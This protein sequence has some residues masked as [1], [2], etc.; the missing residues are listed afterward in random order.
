MQ[1]PKAPRFCCCTLGRGLFMRRKWYL[2]GL[3]AFL[4]SGVSGLW[5]AHPTPAEQPRQIDGQ[6]RQPKAVLPVTQVILFNSGV[7]YFQREGEV[8]AET[9]IDLTFPATD[10]NDLLKSLVLDDKGN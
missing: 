4:V 2:L 8:E 7:G 10:V 5:M 3:F 6:P 9:R 1:P